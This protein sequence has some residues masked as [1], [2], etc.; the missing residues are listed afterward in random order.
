MSSC[1]NQ[2][3]GKEGSFH[4]HPDTSASILS[5]YFLPSRL[6]PSSQKEDDDKHL[7]GLMD[8]K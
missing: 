6:Q 3:G 4:S 8:F 2:A 7:L 5:Q 1:Y